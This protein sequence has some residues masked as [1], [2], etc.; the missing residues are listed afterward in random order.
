MIWEI[1]DVE[2]W[3]KMPEEGTQTTVFKQLHLPAR[4]NE[5]NDW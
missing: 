3:V 5:A 1:R 2:Y 4:W